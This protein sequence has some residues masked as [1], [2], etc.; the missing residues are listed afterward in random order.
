MK[1]LHK[2]NIHKYCLNLNEIIKFAF[3]HNHLMN[4][5]AIKA[6]NLIFFLSKKIK[7]Q[8]IANLINQKVL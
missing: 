2:L 7:K 6:K 8:M 1:E 5:L 3:L 4:N